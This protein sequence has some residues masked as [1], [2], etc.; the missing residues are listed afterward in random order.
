MWDAVCDCFHC[1]LC[2]LCVCGLLSVFEVRPEEAG[3]V[4]CEV[5]VV[6]EFSKEL[7][8]G[9]GV[10]GFGEV[11]VDCE[12]WLFCFDVLVQLVYDCL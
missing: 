7:L 2:V 1:G 6:F 8:V 9:D 12:S 11:Y 10:V 3:G 4:W 5:E